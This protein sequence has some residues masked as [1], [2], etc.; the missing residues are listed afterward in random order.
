MSNRFNKWRVGLAKTSKATFGQIATLLG[1]SE[2]SDET[3]ED[4]NNR[5]DNYGLIS[6]GSF[7]KTG[8]ITVTDKT[9]L[10]VHQAKDNTAAIVDSK[11]NFARADISEQ[12][13]TGLIEEMFNKND[14]IIQKKSRQIDSLET[15]LSVMREAASIP[16]EQI[17]KEV[18]VQYSHIEKFAY[19]HSIETTFN[20]ASD[21]IP[22]FLVKWSRKTSRNTRA[23]ESKELAK[24]LKVRLNLDTLMVVQY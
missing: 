1:G 6:R 11:L 2:I 10:K 7:F 15:A 12:V 9:I 4:L 5:L 24:W 21:T 18:Q 23:R 8:A 16:F 13:R 20:H 14:K 3:I 19:A 22:A 17:A